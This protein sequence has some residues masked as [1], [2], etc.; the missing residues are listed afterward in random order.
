MPD[1]HGPWLERIEALFVRMDAAYDRVA[2]AYGFQCRG[3]EDNC[4]FSRFYHHTLLE[5]LFLHH[6]LGTLAPSRREDILARAKTTAARMA[7]DDR[8]GVLRKRLCPLNDNERCLLYAYRPMVCRL[9][10]L[11]HELCKPGGEPVRS[12]GCDLFVRQTRAVPYIPF[13]RTPLYME[14]ARLERDLRRASG[15]SGR[16]NHTIAE[17]LLL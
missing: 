15:F 8:D 12:P 9:H 16:M 4:C 10:G 3:C 6:G 2:E 1:N 5:Y 11:S 17:M 14:M 13:D 7:G